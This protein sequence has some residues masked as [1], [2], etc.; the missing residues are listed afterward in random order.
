M[1]LLF[2]LENRFFNDL[3]RVIGVQYIIIKFY[4]LN[5]ESQCVA[6]YHLKIMK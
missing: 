3:K 1:K 6:F 5:C 4:P 2:A